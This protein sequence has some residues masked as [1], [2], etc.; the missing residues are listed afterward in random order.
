MIHDFRNVKDVSALTDPVHTGSVEE[1]EIPY[2]G[3]VVEP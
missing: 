1:G 3:R 2:A